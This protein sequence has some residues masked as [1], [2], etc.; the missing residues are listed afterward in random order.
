ML[1][2]KG[3]QCVGLLPAELQNFTSYVAARAATSAASQAAFVNAGI[4]QAH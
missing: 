3:L 4:D 2:D 1:R